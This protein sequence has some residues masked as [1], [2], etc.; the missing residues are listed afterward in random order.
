MPQK[1]KCGKQAK[2]N[3]SGQKKPIYCGKCKTP[4]MIDVVSKRCPC[5]KQPSF[6]LPGKTTGIACA[7]CKKPGMVNVVNKKCPCG[8]RPSFNVPGKTTGIACAKCK[9]PGMIDVMSKRCSCGSS[10]TVFNFPAETV[11]MCCSKCKKPGMVNVMSKRCPCGTIPS[12]NRPGETVGVACAKCKTPEM[13][14]VMSQKCPCGTR[15]YFNMPGK[16]TGIACAK[17]KTPGMVNVVSKR[18]PCGTR[19]YF[20]IPGETVGVCC[21]KCKTPEMIFVKNKMCPGYEGIPCPVRTQLTNGH[22][23]CMSCDPNEDRRKR[24]KLYENAFFEHAKDQLDV[25]KREFVV[26][27][28]PTETAKKFARVDGIVFGDG[29]IVCLE[30]DEN[31]H[32]DYECD[33]HR[34]HLV[35]AELLQKHPGNVVSWVR[36]NPHI[37]SKNE[38]NASSKKKRAKR[39]D[40]VISV[41]K[42]ILET[43]DTRMEY[44][45]FD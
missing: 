19:P 17:C 7:K 9:K 10:S 16:T 23:Y 39:F 26:K 15:P 35:T 14:D 11:G 29:V 32:R 20:N 34:M 13:V 6:N 36:V 3:I 38:W 2:F 8:V 43:R 41:A 37:G 31:G 33:E 12:F 45:G 42:D 27:F 4:E 18:C 22:E 25:H 24:F 30:V 1:C 44:I 40:E 28:D 21:A 5:G